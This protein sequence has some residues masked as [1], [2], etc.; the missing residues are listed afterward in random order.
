MKKITFADRVREVVRHIPKGRT[1][2]YAQVAAAAGSPNASRAVGNIMSHNF[3][4]D[5]PCHRV[6]RADGTPGGYNGGGTGAKIRRLRQERA[7]I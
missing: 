1:M 6:I 2:S 5:V 3:D 7:I 4:P